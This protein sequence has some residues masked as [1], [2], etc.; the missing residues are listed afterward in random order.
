MTTTANRLPFTKPNGQLVDKNTGEVQIKYFPGRPRKYRFDASRGN[1]FLN[2]DPITKPKQPLT[3]IPIAYRIF[4]DDILGYGRKRWAEFFFLNDALHVC[5][6]LVHGYS[7]QNLLK[8]VAD[9]MFYD[10]LKITEVALTITPV[11]RECKSEE[12]KGKKYFIAE[13][14][15]KPVGSD[16]L[17]ILKACTAGLQVW[18]EETLT[19]D[20]KMEVSENFNPPIR[21]E[22]QDEQANAPAKAA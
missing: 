2:S 21:K 9:Q 13:F 8:I 12:A 6:L 22:L 17:E 15:Y 16:D 10:N 11:Q 5:S 18:R 1:F 3:I 19:G 14:S 7:V 4:A 20:A